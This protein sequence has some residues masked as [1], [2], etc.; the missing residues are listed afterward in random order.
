MLSTM[1]NLTFVFN[2]LSTKKNNSILPYGTL[3]TY[4]TK[5]NVYKRKHHE[6]IFTKF[7]AYV[8]N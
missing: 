7:S 1:I 2:P 5:L 4:I 6:V 3:S 8:P